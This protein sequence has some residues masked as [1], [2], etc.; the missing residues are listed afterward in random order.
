MSRA[1]KRDGLSKIVSFTRF[2]QQIPNDFGD[3]PVRLFILA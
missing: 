3:R 2:L 1:K